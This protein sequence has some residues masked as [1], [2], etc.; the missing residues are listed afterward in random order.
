MVDNMRTVYCVDGWHPVSLGKGNQVSE[1]LL[2]FLQVVWE[3]GRKWGGGTRTSHQP[4][5]GNTHT[6]APH[7]PPHFHPAVILP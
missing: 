1:W 4:L 3:K 7:H 2:I 5:E 6:I